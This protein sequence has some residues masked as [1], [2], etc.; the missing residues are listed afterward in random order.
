MT[1][2]ATELVVVGTSWGGLEALGRLLNGLPP[3]F[4]A[5]VAVVQHRGT[6]TPEGAMQKYLADRC[7]LAV[8]D[9]EDKEPVE[10]GHVYLAPP[11]Y[12]LLVDEG[13]L[14]LSTEEPVA[15]SRP[16]IDVLFETAA[17][18]YGPGLVAALLTGA[19]NDGT[20]GIARVHAAGGLVLVQDPDEAERREM[21]DAAISSGVPVEVLGLEAMA[22][23]LSQLERRSGTR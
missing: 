12:H 23:R 21:P 14:A 20:R 7:A 4:H 18:A 6:A 3:D 9:V 22:R 2:A 5:P 17:D 19:N 8:V 15:F 13:S 1:T 11:D 10:P 16:S